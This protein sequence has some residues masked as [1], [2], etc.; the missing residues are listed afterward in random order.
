MWGAAQLGLTVS[1]CS[2]LLLPGSKYHEPILNALPPLLKAEFNERKHDFGVIS[3][4]RSANPDSASCQFFI[5]LGPTPQL[6]SK[7]TAFGRLIK[8]ADVLKKL[9]STPVGQSPSGEPSKPLERVTL[10]NVTVV[11]ADSVK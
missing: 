3:M 5:C 10:E 11:P 7:Y 6:D 4:A 8:G 2:H 1:D 9:G